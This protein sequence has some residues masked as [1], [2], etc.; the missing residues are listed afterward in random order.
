MGKKAWLKAII[1]L[2]YALYLATRC[3]LGQYENYWVK[4]EKWQK[5]CMRKKK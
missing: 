5:W 1:T 2:P 4:L 3:I